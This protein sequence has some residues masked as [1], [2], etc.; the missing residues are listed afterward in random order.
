MKRLRP[1]HLK[2]SFTSKLD[3]LRQQRFFKDRLSWGILVPTV[4]LNIATIVLL[5][6]K[7]HPTDTLVPTHYSSL[8]GFDTLGP[9]YQSYAI[10]VFA[11]GVTVVNGSLAL[12]SFNRSRIT[13]FFLMI[14]A[15][16]VALFCLVISAA[17][18]SIV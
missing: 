6:L 7:F 16:V 15:F 17:F 4:L 10:G 8:V 5:V 12:A 3:S 2:A 11:V 9:W 18:P 1:Q 14:G 13:S